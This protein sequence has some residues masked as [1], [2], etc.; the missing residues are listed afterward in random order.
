MHLGRRTQA[1][2]FL[3]VT[4]TVSV[5]SA[6]AFSPDTWTSGAG[7]TLVW[8]DEFNGTS[9]DLDN[10]TYDVDGGGWCNNELET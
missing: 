2:F 10:W 7:W 4:V 6:A 8:A 5:F 1:A 9:I 3:V